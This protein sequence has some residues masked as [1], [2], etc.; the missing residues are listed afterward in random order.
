MSWESILK[1]FNLTELSK[2]ITQLQ[3][4]QEG[5]Q[6]M[7]LE[8]VSEMYGKSANKRLQNAIVDLI[9]IEKE[10]TL[11][12]REIRVGQATYSDGNTFIEGLTIGQALKG[13]RKKATEVEH[14][15][16]LSKPYDDAISMLLKVIKVLEG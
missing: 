3:T 13:L 15:A 2:L 8:E 12:K 9:M 16:E 10:P 7:N 14:S 1:Q 11:Q 5:I 6:K 4:I